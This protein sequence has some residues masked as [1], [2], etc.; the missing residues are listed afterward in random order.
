MVFSLGCLRETQHQFEPSSSAEAARA[1]AA[2][3]NSLPDEKL[4][5]SSA[6][7]LESFEDF[8]FEI[9]AKWSRV[10]PDRDKTKAMVLLNGTRWDNA[11]GMLKVDVGKPAFP[12]VQQMARTLASNEGVPI[13][14]D[15]EEA[16]QVSTDSTDLSKP[17][18]AIVIFR[19]G[20][21]YLL[22]ASGIPGTDVTTAL[23]HI[24]QTWRW[25]STP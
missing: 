7:E 13:T 23:D 20:K 12:T 14:I 5:T 8:E 10:Q 21:A 6:T 2:P 15:G 11:E 24:V 3:Q 18:H 16:V 17:K 19:D 4:A 22:M 9:P 25:T 1:D